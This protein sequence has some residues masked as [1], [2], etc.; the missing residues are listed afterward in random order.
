MGVPETIMIG[1]STVL[2]DNYELAAASFFSVS[3]FS[4]S[5][6]K[7]GHFKV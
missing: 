6:I 7:Y 1:L 4:V 5:S 3:R 2:E